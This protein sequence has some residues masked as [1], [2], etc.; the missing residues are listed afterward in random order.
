MT[1]KLPMRNLN[2]ALAMAGLLLLGGCGLSSNNFVK[3]GPPEAGTTIR[4]DKVYVY[5]FL[6]LR[7]GMFGATMLAAVNQQITDKLAAAGV[8]AKVLSFKATDTGR[9]FPVTQASADIPVDKV[10]AANSH[11]E[12][13]F[14]ARYRLIVFPLA[15]ETQGAWVIYDLRW[16][17]VDVRSGQDVWI[18]KSHGSH[19]V[20]LQADEQPESRAA[21]VVDDFIAQL[22]K[23]GLV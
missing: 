16:E 22:R 6:D 19:M 7:E 17:L 13:D 20:M 21:E 3:S 1:T 8:K 18:V 10:I 23:Y 4:N 9:Y 11:D 2:R 14:G 12:A 5:S 15:T